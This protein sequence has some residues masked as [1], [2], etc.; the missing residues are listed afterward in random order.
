MNKRMKEIVVEAGQHLQKIIDLDNE[1]TE[2][3]KED[4]FEFPYYLQNYSNYCDDINSGTM[5]SHIGV[6]LRNRLK[7]EKL[8]AE[9][10]LKYIADQL[11]GKW[12]PDFDNASIAYELYY[13]Y[14]DE[15]WTTS[16]TYIKGAGTIYFKSTK[17]AEKA[18]EIMGD[19]MEYLK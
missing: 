13:S 15:V 18:R 11:N 7:N 17:L 10:K 6:A 2:F 9:T 14:E 5:T 4:N 12:V 1:M 8:Y 19:D 3:K 16:H